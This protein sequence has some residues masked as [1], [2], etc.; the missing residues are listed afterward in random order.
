MQWQTSETKSP[1]AGRALEG[2]YGGCLCACQ[3]HLP[4][5][6]HPASAC[7]R[8]QLLPGPLAEPAAVQLPAVHLRLARLLLLQDTRQ[9]VRW[10]T[11][12]HKVPS[13][14]QQLLPA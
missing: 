10:L 12:A 8:L 5:L 4:G 7:C 9:L 1:A 6:L 2:P 3:C 13:H 11:G 14:I